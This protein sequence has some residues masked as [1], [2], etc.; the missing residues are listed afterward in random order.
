MRKAARVVG[1]IWIVACAV[2]WIWIALI[3]DFHPLASWPALSN[4]SVV[5][6]LADTKAGLTFLPILLAMVGA[7]IYSWGTRAP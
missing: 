4:W 5:T 6:L 2:L 7:A 3:S 1:I